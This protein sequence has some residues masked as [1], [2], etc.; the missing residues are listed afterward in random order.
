MKKHLRIN[1]RV[2]YQE[3][4]T[5]KISYLFSNAIYLFSNIIAMLLYSAHD[6]NNHDL[7]LNR[8]HLFIN[9]NYK[10]LPYSD[11]MQDKSKLKSYPLGTLESN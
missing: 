3:T 9:T 2:W 5:K 10:C 11:A 6:S 1:N 4:A 7:K 8:V